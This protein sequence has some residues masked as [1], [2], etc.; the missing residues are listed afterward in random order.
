MLC[1][2]MFMLTIAADGCDVSFSHDAVYFFKINFRLDCYVEMID[3]TITPFLDRL[4]FSE[5]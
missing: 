5:M 2:W 4:F 3:R 1:L